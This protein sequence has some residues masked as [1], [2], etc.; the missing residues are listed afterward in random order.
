MPTHTIVLT[1]ALK[2]PDNEARSA[3]EALR[4]KM[5]LADDVIGLAREDVWELDVDAA[6]AEDALAAA[7][8]LVAATNL[9]ANPNKHRYALA[10]AGVPAD[11]AR[12]ACGDLSPDEAAV[13]VAERGDAAGASALRAVRRAG[14][15]SVTAVRRFA[16]WRVRF[17]QPLSPVRPGLSE[18]IRRIAVTES[19]GEGLLSNPHFQTAHAVLPWGEERTLVA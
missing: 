1:V 4:V 12:R 13:L 6:T 9:F 18:L 7:S 2:I 8:R 17:A 16:R 14:E 11:R 10:D 15:R 5:G 19:R 3:L